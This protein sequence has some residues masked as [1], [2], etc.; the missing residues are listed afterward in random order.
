MFSCP[1]PTSADVSMMN[2]GVATHVRWE[3][4]VFKFINFTKVYL[5]CN[6]KV[7]FEGTVCEEVRSRNILI[8]TILSYSYVIISFVFTLFHK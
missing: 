7:C 2:N 4:K 5:H 3:S 8:F 1:K 6:V